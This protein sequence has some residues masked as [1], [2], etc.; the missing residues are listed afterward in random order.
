MVVAPI[1]A[2]FLK[3]CCSFGDQVDWLPYSKIRRPGKRAG[4]QW[5]AKQNK[6]MSRLGLYLSPHLETVC[7][8]AK[9]NT[10]GGVEPIRTLLAGTF[11]PILLWYFKLTYFHL[12]FIMK[13]CYKEETKTLGLTLRLY[14]GKRHAT[15]CKRQEPQTLK[16]LYGGTRIQWNLAGRHWTRSCV[17]HFVK[18]FRFWWTPQLWIL[19][20]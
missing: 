10:K 3:K 18:Y 16:A 13:N 6:S 14:I 9:G 17:M 2:V 19:L 1:S 7:C 5:Q 20:A 15:L 4:L 12:I 8:N 11:L